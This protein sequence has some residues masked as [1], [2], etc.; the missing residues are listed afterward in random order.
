MKLLNVTDLHTEALVSE[1]DIASV[2][3]GQSIDNTF[4]ALGPD[5]HFTTTVL[6]VNPASTIVSGVVNYKVTG[7]LEKIPE[8]KPGMTDNM[9]I[10]VAEKKGVLAVPSSAVVNKTTGVL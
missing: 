5:K 8:V 1:S 6:T 10:M 7:S 3:V 9:T 2:A 4:D